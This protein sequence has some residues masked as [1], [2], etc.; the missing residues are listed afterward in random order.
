M[1]R[2]HMAETSKTADHALTVL[3]KLV[4]EGPRS[5]AELARELGLNRT[6]VHRL[7][8]TLHERGFVTRLDRGYAPGPILVRIAE[9]VQPELRAAA[10]GVMARLGRQVGETIVMHVADGDDA[11][12]LEQYA[13]STH[14]VRVEH[15]IGSRHS[16]AAG[17]SGRA[18]LAFMAPA[19]VDRL[20]RRSER[21]ESLERELEAVRHLGYA[22]SHD[23]LQ[24]GV[25]GLAVPVVDATGR[26][27]ASLA[28]LVPAARAGG[29]LDHLEALAAA[30]PEI[31][32]SLYG[33][34]GNGALYAR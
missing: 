26:A 2:N 12:V 8:A 30:A 18:L 7:L 32:G 6:V 20:V 9:R 15:D 29:L 21:P 22:I 27:L 1:D 16:L 28:I 24:L 13:A 23:E 10:A 5:A 25:H 19:T 11:V 3:L 31:S 17:A 33:E 14:V 34:P 4:D